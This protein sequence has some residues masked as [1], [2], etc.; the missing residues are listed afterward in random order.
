LSGFNGQPAKRL[1]RKRLLSLNGYI[2]DKN[3]MI[4]CGNFLDNLRD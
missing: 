4:S 3:K 2:S 1:L